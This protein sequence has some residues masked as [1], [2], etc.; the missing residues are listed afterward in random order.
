M[1][2]VRNKLTYANVV[3]SLALFLVLSGATAYAASHLAPN[4]VGAKQ[5]KSS[6]V[7]TSK[8]KRNTVTATKLR[9]G[10]VTATKIEK[11][12]VT[13][14]KIGDGAVTG[15]KIGDGAVTGAKI[16]DGAISAQ[17]LGAQSVGNSQTQLVK[18]FKAGAVAAAASEGAAPKVELGTVGPFHFYAKCF[19]GQ[20]AVIEQSYI[21]LTSG[22][23]T[24]GTVARVLKKSAPYLTPALPES[25]RVLNSIETEPNSIGQ[26]L[27]ATFEA[28]ASDGTTISGIASGGAV[29][30]GTFS[31]GNGPF[32]AGDSCIVGTTA[33]FGGK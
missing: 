30:Q 25:E 6:A 28:A 22:V 11:G 1:Q 29:K 10:S 26:A 23:A 20:T 16:K 15:A 21:E 5:L 4:S 32:L 7:T 33:V 19:H 17:Q 27:G 12:A 18:V 3:A 13:G 31:G 9:L 2:R 24:L 8:L 14:A